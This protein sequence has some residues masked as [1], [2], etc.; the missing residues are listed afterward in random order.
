L[1][2]L[3]RTRYRAG[4]EANIMALRPPSTINRR[5]VAYLDMAE[6][7]AAIPPWL[8]ASTPLRRIVRDYWRGEVA[9]Q[10]AALGRLRARCEERGWSYE[11]T[12]EALG[13]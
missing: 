4:D 2:Y 13:S 6:A 12:V 1:I 7:R 10:S 9:A 8:D 11:S 5:A 3:I